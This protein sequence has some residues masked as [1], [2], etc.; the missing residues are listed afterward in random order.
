MTNI[1]PRGSNVLLRKET[2]DVAA[3]GIVVSGDTDRLARAIVVDKGPG[4]YLS[5][6]VDSQIREKNMEDVLIGD[7]VLVDR[8]CFGQGEAIK[9]GDEE[10]Y[11]V[12]ISSI[13]ATIRK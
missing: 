7:T 6:T 3:S 2:S 9:D 13:Q 8:Y 12:N 11:L 4:A 5:G 1:I 10:Y